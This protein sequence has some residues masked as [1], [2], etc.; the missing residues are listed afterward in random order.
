MAQAEGVN[1][2]KLHSRTQSAVAPCWVGYL[3]K[4]FHRPCISLGLP[5]KEAAGRA[6][7]C[8][9]AG[10]SSA[11]GNTLLTASKLKVRAPNK[12]FHVLT[13]D[14]SSCVVCMHHCELHLTHTFIHVPLYCCRCCQ[15]PCN[16]HA[17]SSQHSEQASTFSRREAFLQL[18]STA[19]LGSLVSVLGSQA[20]LAPAQPAWAAGEPREL[21]G[22]AKAAVDKA[23][24]KFV[25]KSK[26]CHASMHSMLGGSCAVCAEHTRTPLVC[27][28]RGY[29]SMDTSSNVQILHAL[30]HMH[31]TSCTLCHSLRATC[32]QVIPQ[33]AFRMSHRPPPQVPC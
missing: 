18:S 4:C 29:T 10:L 2:H 27:S 32:T 16:R 24:D 9:L 23:L 21:T 19:L 33:D 1:C 8:K 6:S 11:A 20:V 31:V 3:S 22:A 12:C 25:V 30:G 13:N 14:P 7:L 5:H 28:A 17:A 15:P 26:V